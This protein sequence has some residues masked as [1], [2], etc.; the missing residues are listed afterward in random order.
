LREL[1]RQAVVD[2]LRLARHRAGEHLVHAR[3]RNDVEAFLDAL[4]DLHE[5]LGVLFANE[6]CFDASALGREQLP[7]ETGD[8]PHKD[9]FIVNL[10]W[11]QPYAGLSRLNRFFCSSPRDA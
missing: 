9:D 5:V 4:A 11:R 7:L 6:H 8:R 1:Q 2:P 3:N 10:S